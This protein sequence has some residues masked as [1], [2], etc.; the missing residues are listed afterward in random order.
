MKPQALDVPDKR[1][2]EVDVKSENSLLPKKTMY[3]GRAQGLL[4]LP[5]YKGNGMII[6]MMPVI[7]PFS[8]VVVITLYT[9]Q[10]SYDSIEKDKEFSQNFKAKPFSLSVKII[11]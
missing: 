5:G 9:I 4:E 8:P 3:L 1:L 11:S 6:I 7:Q 10:L 2:C